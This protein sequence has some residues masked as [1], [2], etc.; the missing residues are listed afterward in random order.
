MLGAALESIASQ[1]M[2]TSL[3][4]EILVVANNCTDNTDQVVQRYQHDPRI[5]ILRLV[6]EPRQGVA[7]ARKLGMRLAR[8]RWIAFIDDDCR[9]SADWVEEAVGFASAHPRAGGFAGRNQLEWEQPPTDL[10]VAYGESFARQDFGESTCRLPAAQGRLPCGAGLVLRRQAVLASGYLESGI[11]VGREPRRVGAG[12]DTEIALHLHTRGWEFWYTPALRLRHFIPANRMSLSYMCRLHR[13]FGRAE[14]YL[15]LLAERRPRTVRNCLRG[16]GWS[17][18][19]VVRVL[20]RFRKGYMA[21]PDERPTWLIR[22]H[23]AWGCLEGALRLLCTGR[24]G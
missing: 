13:G 18:A 23:Y 11:L 22:W 8:G 20:R 4:W 7:F 19:E 6:H 3:A 17:L 10:C 21:Y 5:P 14:V 15:R 9:L 24:T 1:Q 2:G 16:V 12:E